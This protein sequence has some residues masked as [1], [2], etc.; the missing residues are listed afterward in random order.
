[1]WHNQQFTT[2][3]IHSA[4]CGISKLHL[5][6]FRN[7]CAITELCNLDWCLVVCFVLHMYLCFVC[8]CVMDL[9]K[10]LLI[11]AKLPG[12]NVVTLYYSHHFEIKKKNTHSCNVKKCIHR[13]LVIFSSW[14]EHVPIRHT[15]YGIDTQ[16][17]C[18]GV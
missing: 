12:I 5:H 10:Y 6:E 4:A 1:M 3:V 18:V 16:D 11:A 17:V 14:D 8:V 15:I 13:Q 2:T 7:Y 9:Y